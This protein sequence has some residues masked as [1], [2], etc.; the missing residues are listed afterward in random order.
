MK[1]NSRTNLFSIF[2][3]VNN[4]L[5]DI[6]S[7]GIAKFLVGSPF[8]VWHHTED[9]LSCIAYASNVHQRTIGAVSF[10][11]I[12]VLVAVAP[13]YLSI[14]MQLLQNIFRSIITTFAVSNRNIQRLVLRNRHRHCRI[15]VIG[16]DILVLADE[17]LVCIVQ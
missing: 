10:R 16:L 14:L 17:L 5:Q 3:V 12:A 13:D 9:I 4:R 11:K 6:K 1:N 15:V 2:K 7:I 8:R